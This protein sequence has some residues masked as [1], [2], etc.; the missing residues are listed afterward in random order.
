MPPDKGE[1][2]VAHPQNLA[3]RW[4][5]FTLVLPERQ[6]EWQREHRN[7]LFT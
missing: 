3:R 7:Y 6:A 1:P 4:I 5:G 2:S